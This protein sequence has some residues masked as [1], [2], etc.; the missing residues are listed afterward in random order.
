MNRRG[1][2]LPELLVFVA[3]FTIAMVGFITI[4]VAVTRVQSRQSSASDVETQGQ[5][6]V[7]QLQYYVQSA[8]LV[9]MTLDATT[10]TLTL[11]QTAAS[12][13]LDPTTIF[14]ATGTVYL[15]QGSG[16][17]Q[18]FTS[19]KVTTSNLSF[20]RHYNS[21]TTS[22]AYGIDSVSFSFT[23][24]TAN[25]LAGDPKYY[26]QIFQSSA[27]VSTPTPKIALTQQAAGV[28]NNAGVSTV[29][30]T[31]ATNN[32]TSNLLIAVVSNVGTSTA[33]T[34]I[35]DTAGNTWTL[36]ASTSYTA[37]SQ[38]TVIYNAPNAKNSSNTVTVNFGKNVNYPT[39]FL[40]EY[41]G[42]ATSS[43][44]DASSTRNVA[45]TASP[46]SGFASPTSS[47]ELLF[48]VMYSNPSTEVPVAGTG[49]MLET[50]S[51]VSATYVEDQTTYVTGQAS[52]GF[53]YSG[54]TPSSSVTLVT[55]K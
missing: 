38:K 20:T 23:M 34:S 19:N 2:T 8:R 18:P 51:S 7:Q 27:A 11:R 14:L 33:T 39:L 24:A 4:F 53:S 28:N 1:F 3:I 50:T 36:V 45:N 17:A 31:Y 26:S 21:N 10:S 43:S 32:A 44:F 42:T 13:S 29:N 37:Y 55:F 46:S 12:S 48:G 54:T 35:S 52:A 47:V 22:S 5:F 41:R 6:L 16:S 25:V 40:Y 9:D 49:Y 30:A 15:T